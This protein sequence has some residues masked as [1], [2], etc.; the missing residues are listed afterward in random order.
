M[1]RFLGLESA[2]EDELYEALDWLLE[3]QEKIENELAKKHLGE[4]ALVLYDIS[5]TYFEGKSCP[6]AHYGYSRDKKVTAHRKK[7]RL[8]RIL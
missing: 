6:L 8:L 3:R 1:S 5:S 7:A 4:G 2:D